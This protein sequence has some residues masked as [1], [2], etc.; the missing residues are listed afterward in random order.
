M[1]EWLGRVKI[2]KKLQAGATRDL[3]GTVNVNGASSQREPGGCDISPLGTSRPG[4]LR[5][6]WCGSSSPQSGAV[7]LLSGSTLA[8]KN[9]ILNLRMGNIHMDQGLLMINEREIK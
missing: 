3:G 1:S 2:G 9:H 7:V 4:K 5:R 8:K 6:L